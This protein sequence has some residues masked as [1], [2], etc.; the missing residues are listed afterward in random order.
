MHHET[1]EDGTVLNVNLYQY[2]VPGRLLTLRVV[3]TIMIIT[4]CCSGGSRMKTKGEG[5]NRKDLELNPEI[6]G[7]LR[8]INTYLMEKSCS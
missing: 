3:F 8:L 7:D 6:N 4:P 5:L 2:P 1:L